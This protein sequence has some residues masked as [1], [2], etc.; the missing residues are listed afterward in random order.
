MLL[1]EMVPRNT[2]S[3]S[4]MCN[5]TS[6]LGLL[7]SVSEINTFTFS[8]TWLSCSEG[9]RNPRCIQTEAIK[10]FDRKPPAVCLFSPPSLT[11]PNFE[12]LDFSFQ[13]PWVFSVSVGEAGLVAVAVMLLA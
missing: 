7:L 8:I 12:I 4:W 1:V 13:F 3:K 11:I 9:N 2:H 6:C 5:N 10:E